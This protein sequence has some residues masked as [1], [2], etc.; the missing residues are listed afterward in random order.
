V[1]PGVRAQAPGPPAAVVAVAPSSEAA[2]GAPRLEL[3][4]DD[5]DTLLGETLALLDVELAALIAESDAY[6]GQL[7]TDPNPIRLE[8]FADFQARL[9]KL[10]DLRHQLDAVRPTPS[11]GAR[12]PAS[13]QNRIQR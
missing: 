12:A 13:I 1:L 8:E 2:A 4:A 5:R 9:I 6:S 11:A 7:L 3:A 10:L